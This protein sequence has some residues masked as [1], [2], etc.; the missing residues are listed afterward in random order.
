MAVPSIARLGPRA[1]QTSPPDKPDAALQRFLGQLRTLV[2]QT[3]LTDAMG[4]YPNDAEFRRLGASIAIAFAAA[5]ALILQVAHPSIG[6]GVYDH[7]DFE[8]D[9]VGRGIRTFLG[10]FMIGFG[11]QREALWAAE[12]IYST[13]R[14][15][16]GTI[17]PARPG[18][19][20]RRYSALDPH[21][22]LWVW[23]TL[24]EGII[25]GH[26][27][28]GNRLPAHRI[29]QMYQESKLFARFFNVR[30]SIIPETWSDFQTYFNNMVDSG[31]EVTPAGQAVA[32]ALVKGGKFPYRQAGWALR[33]F[34]VETL[35]PSVRRQ[36]GWES[37][38]QTR[39]VYGTIRA[40][41][42]AYV[43]AAPESLTVFPVVYAPGLREAADEL[44]AQLD[45]LGLRRSAFAS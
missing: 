2:D 28:L 17:P 19:K 22:S 9:P 26:Q 24:V 5:R 43:S 42:R 30:A 39:L 38:R 45:S 7:S 18:Q 27:E 35:P 15:I 4:I 20:S 1:D 34:A 6:Q 8:R 37:R 12:K 13:H 44:A 21:A 3:G 25:Y 40:A 41:A 29:E 11:R 31:L 23:A 33:A 36:L 10:V 32:D 14:L 16:K